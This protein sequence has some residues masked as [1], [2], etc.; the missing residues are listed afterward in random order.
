MKTEAPSTGSSRIRH[1]ASVLLIVLLSPVLLAF[2]LAYLL[3]WFSFAVVLHL[4]IWVGW[5]SRGKSVLLVYSNSPIWQGYFETHILPRLGQRAV[6]LNWSERKNWP[7]F[8]SL[9]VLAFRC[10][11]GDRE[12]NPLAVVF[13]PFRLR[14]TFRFWQPF[15]QLK[16]EKP[17]A[18]EAMTMN[19]FAFLEGTAGKILA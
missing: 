6:V 17:E 14:R 4:A 15:K 11:G 19:L 18:V 13:R 12:F 9:A 1:A 16:H 10:F 3:S 5:C 2:A 7:R 8:S